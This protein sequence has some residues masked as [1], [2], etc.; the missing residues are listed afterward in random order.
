MCMKS[1]KEY[2]NESDMSSY[3]VKKFGWAPRGEIIS[4]GGGRGKSAPKDKMEKHGRAVVTHIDKGGR[5]WNS[6]IPPVT[7]GFAR[8]KSDLQQ[9]LTKFV[10][11]IKKDG[12]T[13]ID[14]HY[15]HEAVF[16]KILKG[17]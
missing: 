7:Y 10:E 12:A 2:L 4:G 16:K 15:A 13:D 3:Y 8:S 5:E 6:V 14:V 17:L 1:F 9:A 11:N